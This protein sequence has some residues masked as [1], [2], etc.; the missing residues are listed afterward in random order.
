LLAGLGTIA[1]KMVTQPKKTL[2]AIGEFKKSYDKM[3]KANVIGGRHTT[4]TRRPTEKQPKCLTPKLQQ[5][6]VLP[7]SST[8]DSF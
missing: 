6:S 3:K 2:K 4:D 8:R 7:G 1:K 5:L